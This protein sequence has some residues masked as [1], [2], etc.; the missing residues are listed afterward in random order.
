MRITNIELTGYKRLSLT[1][2][3]YLSMTMTEKV[4]FILGTNGSGK[5][6][7]LKELSP[8]PAH[9]AQ[10]E[11]DGSKCIEIDHLGFHY[12]LKSD[13][14]TNKHTLIKQQRSETGDI[15][16]EDN[17]NPG[18]TQTVQ[19]ELVKKEFGI[20]QELH[21]L[22]TGQIKFHRM[23]VAERRKWFTLFSQSDYTYALAIYQKFK[24]SLRDAQAN[25]KMT[26]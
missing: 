9:S 18:G 8:L 17:L 26:Q 21:D 25:L 11:K 24:D 7:L 5:S 4:I 20:T 19:R 12:I 10:F 22:F 2:I 16:F 1:H 15:V 13:F 6:S 14:S 3:H 23:S